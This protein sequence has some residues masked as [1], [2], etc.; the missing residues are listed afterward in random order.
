M[1]RSR[2]KLLHCSGLRFF[3]Q[4]WRVAAPG[5]ERPDVERVPAGVLTFGD[6]RVS[7]EV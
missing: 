4:G 1:T 6:A 3:V 7:R 2:G 5:R